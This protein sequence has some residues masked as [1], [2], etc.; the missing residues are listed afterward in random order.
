MHM[1]LHVF[2]LF[3]IDFMA[4]VQTWILADVLCVLIYMKHSILHMEGAYL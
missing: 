1:H 2:S 3:N 4:V